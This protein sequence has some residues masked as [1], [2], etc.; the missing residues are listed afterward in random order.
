MENLDLS[1]D[2]LLLDGLEHLDDTFLVVDDVDA[3]K[4]LGILSPA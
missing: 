3:L 4:Y 1:L 2:L